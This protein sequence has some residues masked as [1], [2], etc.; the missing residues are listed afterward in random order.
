MGVWLFML[1]GVIGIR[2]LIPDALGEKKKNLIFLVLSFAIVVFVV[3]SRSA[4]LTR[5]LDLH[6]YY[7]WY[8]R[9][10]NMPLDAMIER[11]KFETGYLVLNKILATIVPWNYFIVYFEAAFTTAI[12]F[13]YIY[14]NC[15]SVFLGVIIYICLGPWQ[16]FLTGFRQAI[17]ICMCIVALEMMKKKTL[18]W[19]ILVVFIVMLAS[20]IHTTALIF[21]GAFILRK[22]KFNKKLVLASILMTLV[23]LIFLDDIVTFGN[24]ILERDYAVA[25]QGSAIAGIV[26]IM[27]FIGTFILWYLIWSWN[28]EF[29][30]EHEFE[31][32]MLLVGLCLYTLRYT[33]T[34]ME[35]TSYYYT[36]VLMVVLSNGITRQK[37]KIVRNIA[38]IIC[39][40]LCV[41]LFAYRA[42][43]QLGVYHF[44][45]E[46]LERYVYL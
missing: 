39:V 22:L 32:M 28:N 9:A 24:D 46:Y 2:F 34:I 10:L 30:K 8:G 3:G 23:M 21:F 18:L 26:P 13:W 5:S 36:F 44:Y 16:F 45:W 27:V 37:T 14:R 43:S 19:D 35:R 31:L 4:F 1:L 7:T 38:M 15:D 29:I 41:V 42:T 33:I 6:N 17:A 25:Y 40:V 20:T 11:S 12:V